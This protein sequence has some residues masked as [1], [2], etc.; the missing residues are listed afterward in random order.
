MNINFIVTTYDKEEY[1]PYLVDIFKNYKKINPTYSVIY[2]GNK[3]DFSANIKIEN[4]IKLKSLFD[5]KH[6]ILSK[7]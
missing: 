7:I 1:L 5:L 4:R 3:L 2:T 6:F